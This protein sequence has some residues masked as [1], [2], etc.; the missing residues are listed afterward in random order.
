MSETDSDVYIGL[1]L[2]TSGL[3]GVA[4]APDGTVA[5]RGGAAY[6]TRRPSPGASEQAPQGWLTA[7]ATGVALLR[8]AGAPPRWR[9]IG[10]SANDPTLVS[11]PPGG[12]PGRPPTTTQA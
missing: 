10:L 5:A 8:E 7:V 11:P 3:K 6:P 1:D 12:E 4:L 2:G 9:G